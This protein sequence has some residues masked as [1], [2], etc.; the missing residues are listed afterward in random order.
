M[1]EVKNFETRVSFVV[2]AIKLALIS[3]IIIFLSW[4]LYTPAAVALFFKVKMTLEFER[5]Q[6]DMPHLVTLSQTEDGQS[7]FSV[8]EETLWRGSTA[9]SYTHLTLPTN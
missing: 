1:S 2:P 9:V 5:L 3:F 8:D 6:R 4:L 7:V